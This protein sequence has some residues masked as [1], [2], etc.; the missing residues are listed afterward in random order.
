M[1]LITTD[2]V[3]VGAGGTGLRVA[4]AETNPGLGVALNADALKA[5]KVA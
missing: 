1:D 3:I 2:A 4:V 5:Y